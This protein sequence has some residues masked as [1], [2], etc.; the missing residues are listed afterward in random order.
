MSTQTISLTFD[1]RESLRGTLLLS[2]V[3][4]AGLFVGIVVYT[5]FGPRFGGGGWGQGWGGGEA[6]RVGVVTSLPGVPLPTPMLTTR[7]TL[8]TENPGL[9]QSE[10]ELKLPPIEQ[11]QEIP[12]FKEAVK[13]EKAE[14]IN[15]R[16]QKEEAQP[17]D[18]AI[19]FGLGGPP[20]MNYAQVVNAA[21]SGGLS[22]GEGGSFGQRYGW[23]VASVRSRI[24][25]NWLLSTVSPSILTAPRIYVTFEVVRD[26]TITNVQMTQSSGIPEVD[27]SALRAILASNPLPPLPADYGGSR[28]KVEF[29]F[30]FH[31]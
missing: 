4:H 27:R 9:H 22:L 10:P 21:G 24:S 14:R 20:T 19:P 18:N 30:D 23:Y 6:T 12:K 11:A 26:G 3:L 16:I 8:A 31:R 2:V 1:H 15:K 7:S 5:V 29:Y 13:P 28:V 25:N 17:R